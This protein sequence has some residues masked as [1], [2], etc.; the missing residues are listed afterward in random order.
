MYTACL[1]SLVLAMKIIVFPSF[2]AETTNVSPGNTCEVKR[3]LTY[4]SCSGCSLKKCC[5][6]AFTAIPGSMCNGFLSLQ[7]LYRIAWF[8]VVG[9]SLVMSGARFGTAGKGFLIV[10]L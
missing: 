5:W 8:L 6:T 9:S 10:P 2:Q 1:R 4:L 7:S 3:T